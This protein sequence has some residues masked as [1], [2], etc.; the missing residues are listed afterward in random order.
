MSY[1]FLELLDQ[2]FRIYRDN[3]LAFV[4]LTALV[5]IPLTVVNLLV[6]LPA[7]DAAVDVSTLGSDGTMAYS[8]S[9]CL[10]GLVSFVVALLQ[11]VLVN[12]PITYMTS[13]RQMGRRVSVADAF[14]A[15][16]PRFASLGF[17]FVTFYITLVVFTMAV[18]LLSGALNF[19]PILAGLGVVAYIGIATYALL[20]PVLVLENVRMSFGVSRAWSLGKARFWTTFGLMLAL[21]VISFVISLAFTALTQLMV[22]QSL[23]SSSFV[24]AQVIDAVLT[25]LVN[26]FLVPLLPIGLTLL[27]YDTRTRVEGLD[28]ALQALDNPEARPGDVVSFPGGARLNS[29]DWINIVILTG[30]ALVIGVVFSTAAYSLLEGILPAGSLSSF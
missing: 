30:A 10:S 15:T 22:Q 27:Y 1:T 6:T 7:L 25:T 16:R 26:V 14:S 5:T 18:V 3:F 29:Q 19:A 9:I 2:T 21:F 13:E 24:L 8:S 12:A 4:S 17:G 23:Q 20:V 11:F 28:L